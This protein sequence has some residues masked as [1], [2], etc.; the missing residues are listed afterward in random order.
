MLLM[1]RLD[2]LVILVQGKSEARCENAGI[3][4]GVAPAHAARSRGQSTGTISR[5]MCKASFTFSWIDLGALSSTLVSSQS[6]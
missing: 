4:I 5:S 3:L 6:T 2:P 1:F